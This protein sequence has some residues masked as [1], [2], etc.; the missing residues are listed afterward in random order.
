MPT[1]GR[2]LVTIILSTEL[3]PEMKHLVNDP[4]TVFT[5]F[6]LLFLYF[7]ILFFLTML[8]RHFTDYT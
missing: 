5:Y 4:L 2:P 3:L 6:F 1:A 7:L 8:K